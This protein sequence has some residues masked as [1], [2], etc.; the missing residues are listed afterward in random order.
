MLGR[1]ASMPGTMFMFVRCCTQP[2]RVAVVRVRVR[3]AE[4]A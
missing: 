3:E 2:R 4:G 1:G